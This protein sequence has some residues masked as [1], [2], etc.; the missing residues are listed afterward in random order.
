MIPTKLTS[1]RARH[2]T[3]ALSCPLS[4]DRHIL[5]ACLTR[6]KGAV[7][8]SSRS[9]GSSRCMGSFHEQFGSLERKLR[10]PFRRFEPLSNGHLLTKRRAPACSTAGGRTPRSFAP[11][12]QRERS[13]WSTR[14]RSQCRPPVQRRRQSRRL[15]RPRT[16]SEAAPRRQPGWPARRW[17]A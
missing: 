14:S 7:A 16:S 10:A 9:A 2:Q 6:K 15:R 3:A 1:T 13:R 5:S 8:G 17:P 4:A 12:A 11:R